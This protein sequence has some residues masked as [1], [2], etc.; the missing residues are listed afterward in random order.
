MRESCILFMEKLLKAQ[1]HE[2][3]KLWSSIALFQSCSKYARKNKRR[4]ENRVRKTEDSSYSLPSHFW[5]TSRNPF[6]TFYIPFQSS[7]SQNPTLQTV[8]SCNSLARKYPWKGKLPSYINSLVNAKKHTLGELSPGDQLIQTTSEDVFPE[9]ERLNFWFL[10]VKEA[11][12]FDVC[13]NFH[14]ASI[15]FAVGMLGRYQSNPGMDHWKAAKKVMS[16]GSQQSNASNGVRFGVEMKE[17]QPLEADQSKLKENFARLR[18]HPFAAK[19][20]SNSEDFSSED[21][22]L[23]SSSLGVKKAGCACHVE[24]EIAEEAMKFMSYVAEFQEDG[25]NQML[26][27]WE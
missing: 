27:I 22:R 16:S 17:L 4:E 8:H 11:R 25:M 3:T 10:G 18:N 6:S 21:E 23:G 1:I 20:Q 24:Y 26:E 7:G 19:I 2:E 13:T 12:K 9:D 14:Y 15:S 5:S